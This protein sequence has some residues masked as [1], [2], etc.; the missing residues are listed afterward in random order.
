MVAF[1]IVFANILALEPRELIKEAPTINIT[2][3]QE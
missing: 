2:K 1:M 3:V